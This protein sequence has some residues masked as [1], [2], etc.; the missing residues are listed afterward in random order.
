MPQLVDRLLLFEVLVVDQLEQLVV[1]AAVEHKY[2]GLLVHQVL[3]EDL[4]AEIGRQVFLL[5]LQ[6]L[7]EVLLELLLFV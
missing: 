5:L 6:Q 4:K 1:L 3:E 2:Q 7:E